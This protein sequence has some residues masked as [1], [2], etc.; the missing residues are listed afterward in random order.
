MAQL[1][2]AAFTKATKDQF[3]AKTAHM[4]TAK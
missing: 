1:Y 2:L 3:R 4:L